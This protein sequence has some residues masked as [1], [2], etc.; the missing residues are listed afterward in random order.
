[1]NLVFLGIIIFIVVVI[2][3]SYLGKS[4]PKKISKGI[5]YIIIFFS[6]ILGLILILAGKIFV[7]DSTI[8][9]NIAYN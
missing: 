6:V 5:R 4:D 1:M 2:V 3:L 7:C 9:F 8:F